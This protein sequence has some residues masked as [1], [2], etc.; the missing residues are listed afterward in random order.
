MCCDSRS[1]GVYYN[2]VFSFLQYVIPWLVN[3]L[4]SLV[5]LF[6]IQRV[7]LSL[8]MPAANSLAFAFTALT[9]SLVGTE[10]PLDQGMLYCTAGNFGFSSIKK[11]WTPC[12]CFVIMCLSV[13]NMCLRIPSK[14]FPCDVFCR[15]KSL[16][17]LV[18]SSIK[19]YMD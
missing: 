13:T 19:A 10:R 5:Y 15:Q 2:R 7:P 12:R 4:G 14:S 6:A 1:E 11:T 17:V 3:Q 16:K 18:K 9:G 8:A